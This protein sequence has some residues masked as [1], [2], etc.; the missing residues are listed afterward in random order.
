[1]L[2]LALTLMFGCRHPAPTPA[3]QPTAG[4]FEAPADARVWYVKAVAAEEVGDFEEARRA[5][6][7]VARLDR[8]SPWPIV[9]RG[10]LALVEGDPAGAIEAFE[11]A[12]EVAELF[13]AHV[14]L[15]RARLL[16]G[17]EDGAR[18]S[19][20]EACALGPGSD[21]LGGPHPE[22]W[23]DAWAQMVQEVEASGAGCA[24]EVP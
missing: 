9:A 1:M 5:L 7:W 22:R 15:A 13:E 21:G 12:L 24:T 11:T 17:D 16:S 20:M 18:A 3:A 6:Q 19:L 8:S 14:G 23:G 2:L 4:S 10:R